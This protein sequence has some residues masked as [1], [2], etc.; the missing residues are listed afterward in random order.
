MEAQK[1]EEMLTLT[2]NDVIIIYNKINLSKMK[3]QV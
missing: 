2:F 1:E 3:Y